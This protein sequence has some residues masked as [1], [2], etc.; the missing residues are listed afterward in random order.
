[1]HAAVATP[2]RLMQK[3]AELEDSLGYIVNLKSV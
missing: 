3:N 1:V 2:E